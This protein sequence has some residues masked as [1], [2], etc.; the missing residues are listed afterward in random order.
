[1]RAHFILHPVVD[2]SPHG[3]QGRVV[4]CLSTERHIPPG[5]RPASVNDARRMNPVDHVDRV[6]PVETLHATSLPVGGETDL[7]LTP[8]AGLAAGTYTATLTV[9]AEGITSLTLTVSHVVTPTGIESQPSATK[10]WAHGSVLYVA[11]ATSG[12][13][14]IYNVS[15]QLVKTVSHFAGET[16]TTQLPDGVYIVVADGKTHKVI[17]Q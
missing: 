2:A 9:S 8:R 7:T 5:C 10:V 13:A 6:D 12:D 11:A 17:V 3:M 16:T 14:Y 15:G 1:M 4:E